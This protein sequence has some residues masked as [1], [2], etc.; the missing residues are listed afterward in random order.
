MKRHRLID[1][2]E[3]AENVVA[4]AVYIKGVA[5]PGGQASQQFNR[6]HALACAEKL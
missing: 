6:A 2:K 3:W 1:K 5:A 4:R